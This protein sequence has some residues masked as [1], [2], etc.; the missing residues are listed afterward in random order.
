MTESLHHPIPVYFTP[1]ASKSI[2]QSRCTAN[3]NTRDNL[4][5]FHSPSFSL[6]SFT[7]TAMIIWIPIWFTIVILVTTLNHFL[8]MSVSHHHYNG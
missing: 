6:F 1:T 5:A 2:P 8:E 3:T 7:T 4:W